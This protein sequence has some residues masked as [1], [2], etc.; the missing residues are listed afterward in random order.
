MMLLHCI[1]LLCPGL[2]ETDNHCLLKVNW[3][4]KPSKDM[5]VKGQL[6]SVKATNTVSEVKYCQVTLADTAT[7]DIGFVLR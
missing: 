7:I 2:K 3:Q 6:P 1:S 4:A 5:F